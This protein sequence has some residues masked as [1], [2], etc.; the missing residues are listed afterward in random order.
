MALGNSATPI[1][2]NAA[3]VAGR[4][5]QDIHFGP[6][7]SPV[8][9]RAVKRTVGSID[10]PRI[11]VTRLGGAGGAAGLTR[12]LLGRGSRPGAPKAES[13]P[14]AEKKTKTKKGGAA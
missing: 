13:Q 9:V 11:G 8:R 10:S 12:R 3:R 4:R 14:K 2:T 7:R 1:N 6:A 5:S